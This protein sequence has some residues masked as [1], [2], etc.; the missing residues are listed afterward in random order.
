MPPTVCSRPPPVA[1]RFRGAPCARASLRSR[2]TIT[3][4]RALRAPPAPV[5]TKMH[6]PSKPALHPFGSP[7]P[8]FRLPRWTWLR[9]GERGIRWPLASGG[10]ARSGGWATSCRRA[11]AR[12]QEGARGRFGARW[13]DDWRP[14]GRI[15]GGLTLQRRSRTCATVN[16][17]R[18]RRGCQRLRNDAP[19]A[20]DELVA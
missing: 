5:R 3:G 8:Q 12:V 2:P 11:L 10:S 13:R 9:R 20:P 18:G 16:P 15:R 6:V 1:I 14:S 17:D 19:D 7:G 4:S